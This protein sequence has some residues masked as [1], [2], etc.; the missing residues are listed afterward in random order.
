M[1]ILILYYHRI[2]YPGD[3]GG[4]VT[5]E[6]FRA[7]MRLLKI[8]QWKFIGMDEV[9]Y[10]IHGKRINR[11]RALSITFDDAYRDIYINAFPV[12]KEMRIPA[13]VYAVSNYVG[14]E[15]LWNQ[16]RRPL[17]PLCSWDE[18]REMAEGGI[19]IGS[20]SSTHRS[21]ISLNLD[22]SVYEIAMS[23]EELQRGLGTTVRHFSYPFGH[24]DR[25]R[26][27]IVKDAG[28]ETACTTVKGSV[29]PGDDPY[30]LNRIP[31]TRGM[32]IF[33][34]LGRLIKDYR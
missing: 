16:G 2:G 9:G 20:H 26:A 28:Y 17:R 21:L 30:K 14:G 7:Q 18:L 19:E 34:F 13:T 25:E 32:N 3:E 8:L 15:D 5:P 27:R 12:L 31:V 22:D 11:R 1:S 23:R 29:R 4:T 6:A 24:H 10:I 33:R